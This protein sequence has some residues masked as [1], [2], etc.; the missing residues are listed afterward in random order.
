MASYRYYYFV[1]QLSVL[2]Y[3]QPAPTSSAAFREKAAAML[4]AGDAALLDMVAMEPSEP[5]AAGSGCDFIDGVREWE[6]ALRLSLAGLRAAALGRDEGATPEPPDLPG[7][8]QAAARA[9]AAE[10]PIE[11]EIVID[12]ARWDAV[13]AM[14]G[15][16]LFHRN[17]VLAYLMKLIILE[18]QAS[19]Q[20]EAGFSQYK[21]LYGS[22]LERWGASATG[23]S[24]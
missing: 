19:F 18:R 24:K 2:S 4:D 12:R 23:E 5:G 11:G 22:I 6:R 9:M 16:E 14:Q 1:P 13:E 7:A 8:A 3:G 15:T 21:S 17:T 10:T 20:A